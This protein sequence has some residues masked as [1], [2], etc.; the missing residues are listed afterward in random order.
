MAVKITPARGDTG[1]LI[2][3]DE[4][5]QFH[6]YDDQGGFKDYSMLHCDLEITITDADAAFYQYDNGTLSLDHSPETLGL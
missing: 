5:Y 2:W 3:T 4:G 1:F 6:V